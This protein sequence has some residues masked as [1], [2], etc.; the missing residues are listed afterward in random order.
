MPLGAPSW[1]QPVPQPHP[2]HG[3]P[4][5]QSTPRPPLP[6]AERRRL[7]R[8]GASSGAL[9]GL[10]AGLGGTVLLLWTT[11]LGISALVAPLVIAFGGGDPLGEGVAAVVTPLTVAVLAGGSVLCLLGLALGWFGLRR[12]GGGRAAGV[13]AAAAA[14]ASVPVH[15]VNIV[16]VVLTFALQPELDESTGIA[17]IALVAGLVGA[18][19]G[20]A[21]GAGAWRWMGAALRPRQPHELR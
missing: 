4:F 1:Q 20:A 13:T 15:L 21:A 12:W 2:R 14:I 9:L 19:V 17:I 3:V 16:V 11:V 10:G 6:E 8:L 18:V 5:P 7:L